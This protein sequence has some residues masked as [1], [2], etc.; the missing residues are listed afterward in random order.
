MRTSPRTSGGFGT[1]ALVLLGLGLLVACADVAPTNPY[2]PATPIAQQQKGQV[3]GTLRLPPG[4]GVDRLADAVVS[5]SAASSPAAS[6]YDSPV[7]V[8]ED[9][10]G[11]RFTF[12]DIDPGAYRLTVGVRGLSA[13]PI[14]LEVGIGARV[15]VG[16]VGLLAD[17]SASVEGVALRGGDAV[18]S[19][20]GILVE[21]LG[22]PYTALTTAEGRFSVSLTPGTYTFRFSVAGHA[23]RERAGVEVRAGATTTLPDPV[24]LLGAP[25]RIRGQVALPAGFDRDRMRDVEVALFAPAQDEPAQVQ[26]PGPQGTFVLADLTPGAWRVEVRLAGFTA[27][28]RVAEV[29]PGGDVDV[30]LITLEQATQAWISGVARLAGRGDDVHGGIAIE[31]VGTPFNGAT[32]SDGSFRL[33]VTPGAHSVRVRFPGYTPQVVPVEALAPLEDR[34]LA[35][36]IVLLG[37]PGRVTGTAALA[38]GFDDRAALA[39]MVVQAR[40]VGEPDAVTVLDVVIDDADQAQI[41][42]A[43]AAGAWDV[44]LQ[45]AGFYPELRRVAVPVGAAVDLG[46]VVLRSLPRNARVTGV[47]QIQGAADHADIA[48]ELVGTPESTRTNSDGDF[49][50]QVPAQADPYRLRVRRAGYEPRL[51]D[52]PGQAPEAV[53]ALEDPIL[54]V[55]QPGSV[56]GVVQIDERFD[57]RAL[58]PQVEVRLSPIIDGEPGEP[59]VTAPT[60]NG[61]YEFDQLPPGAY[62]LEVTLDGFFSAFRA[63][64]VTVGA[65][66]NVG[67]VRLSPNQAQAAIAGTARLQCPTAQCDNG[68]IRVEAIGA[69][70][71]TFTN[72]DGDFQL[73]VVVGEYTLRFVFAGYAAQERGPIAVD[74]GALRDDVEDVLLL[75]LPGRILG[76]LSLPD[77]FDG[78]ALFAQTLVDVFP[79]DAAPA[80]DEVGAP[81][82]RGQVSPDGLFVVSDVTLGEW[83]VRVRVPGFATQV[84]RVELPPGGAADLGVLTLGIRQPARVS[85]RITLEDEVTHGGIQVSVRGQPFTTLTSEDGAFALQVLAGQPQQLVFARDGF[86]TQELALEPVAV[87]EQR[88]LNDVVIMPFL[89][90]AVSGTILRRLPDG[91]TVPAQNATVAVRGDA[92]VPQVGVT[93]AQG[94]YTVGDLRGGAYQVRADLER[95]VSVGRAAQLLPG[96]TL[97]IEPLIVDIERGR[98]IGTATRDDAP[99][100]GGVTVLAVRE[101]DGLDLGDG[102]RA[103]TLSRAPTDAIELDLPVGNWRVTALAE[104][105]RPFGPVVV[106]VR[107]DADTIVNARVA[108][109][110]HRLTAPERVAEGPVTVTLEGDADLTAYK[111]WVDAAPVP[112]EWSVLPADG[113]IAV[114]LAGDGPHQLF[115]Q[116]ATRAEVDAGDPVLRATSPVL[117]AVVVLDGTPPE[118]LPPRIASGDVVTSPEGLVDLELTCLDALSVAA[119]LTV[120]VRVDGVERYAGPYRPQVPVNLGVDEGIKRLE[121]RCT[122]AAGNTAISDAVDVLHDYS[123]PTVATFCLG[124]DCAPGATTNDAVVAVQLDVTDAGAGGVE[125][126]LAEAAFA[127]ADGAYVFGGRGV[128]DVRLSAPGERTLWLCARDR[129]GNTTAAAVES[130]NSITLDQTAPQIPTLTGPTVTRAPG[131][132]VDLA[133]PPEPGLQVALSGDIAP[134]T[135]A[136]E[137]A[138]FAVALTGPDGIKIIQAR[139]IDAAGNLSNAA[140]LLV[141]LDREAPAAGTVTLANGQPVVNSR[142]VPITITDTVADR[143]RFWS[144]A[145]CG[146]P[147]CG[148]DGF[149]D[150]A[151]ATRF[152]VTE[153]LG[154]KR[155]CWQ[156]CDAA[157][158]AS[159]VGT[160]VITLDTYIDRPQ[161]ALVSV[162]RPVIEAFP[163]D[164]SIV[165]TGAGI[166]P[167]T[168]L[169]VDGFTVACASD[170]EAGCSVNGGC[171]QTCTAT[172]PRVVVQNPDT[173][174]LRLFTPAPVA[175]GDGTSADAVVLNVVGPRPVITQLSPRGILES[176][177]DDDTIDVEITGYDFMDNRQVLLDRFVGEVIASEVVDIDDA[178]AGAPQRRLTV[179]FALDGLPPAEDGVDLALTVRNPAPGGGE[180]V[181]AFGWNPDFVDC[182]AL[183]SCETA[184]SYTRA[185]HPDGRGGAQSYLLDPALAGM[186][187]GGDL[188]RLREM[189]GTV[190]G[191]IVRSTVA[192]PPLRPVPVLDLQDRTGRAGRFTVEPTTWRTSGE[193]EAEPRETALGLEK[194][195]RLAVGDIDGDGAADVIAVQHGPGNTP[196]KIQVLTWQDGAL[197]RGPV[198]DEALVATRAFKLVDLDGDLHLDL[199][200][201]T[202]SDLYF[203]R[204]RGDTTFAPAARLG[205][206]S[207]P[208]QL[209]VG[210]IDGDGVAEVAVTDQSDDAVRI[211]GLGP[212]ARVIIKARLD[213]QGAR[214]VA[215]DDI[216]GD[217]VADILVGSAGDTHIR[218]WVGRGAGQFRAPT[219]V[220]IVEAAP[221]LV[222]Q[223]GDLNGDGRV[224][225]LLGQPAGLLGTLGTGAAIFFGV[226]F[227]IVGDAVDQMA[228]ID[229]DGDGLLDALYL[230]DDGIVLH[231]RIGAEL[232]DEPVLLVAG[233]V[234]RFEVADVDG[235]GLLDIISARDAATVELYRGVDGRFAGVYLEPVWPNVVATSQPRWPRT[236]TLVEGRV[237]GL[238]ALD[239]AGVLFT[240]TTGVGVLPAPVLIPMPEAVGA[241]KSAPPGVGDYNG[242]GHEDF[243]FAVS[244]GGIVVGTNAGDGGLEGMSRVLFEN[245]YEQVAFGDFGGDGVHRIAAIGDDLLTIKANGVQP[246]HLDLAAP[247]SHGMLRHGLATGDIDLDGRDDIAY[248]TDDG[249]IIGLSR[250]CDPTCRFDFGDPIEPALRTLELRDMDGDGHLDLVGLETERI[251][252]VHFLLGAGPVATVQVNGFV[253]EAV[254][255][256]D[257]GIDD[258]DGDGRLDLIFAGNVPVDVLGLT[259]QTSARGFAE[260]TAVPFAGDPR[261]IVVDD[262]NN[263][264]S[265]DIV[266][267]PGRRV[268]S[269]DVAVWLRPAPQTLQHRL[270]DMRGPVTIAPG[271]AQTLTVGAARMFLRS[272]GLHVHATSPAGLVDA[273][274][275][276]TDPNGVTVILDAPPAATTAQL[277]VIDAVDGDVNRWLERG[278]WQLEIT[279]TG[280]QA[281]VIDDFAVLA[282]GDYQAGCEAAIVDGTRYLFCAQ[283]LTFDDARAHCQSRGR[284]LVI[285]DTNAKNLAVQAHARATLPGRYWIGLT[286]RAVERDFAWIDGRPDGD[287]NFNAGEPNHGAGQDCVY[288]RLDLD[289]GVW[290]DFRCDARL[291]FVCE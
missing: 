103:V 187:V 212:D 247:A 67:I 230:T 149:T 157:G 184:L 273:R 210:D 216:N 73:P 267:L 81:T 287:F 200:I 127:C 94:A 173:Y 88:A 5:L 172:L 51:I 162:D 180:A 191:G 194:V 290:H 58:M 106:E 249:V 41:S 257:L 55:G 19:H 253:A 123:P 49:A 280:A 32:N 208:G 6:A 281:L 221:T 84:L 214:S 264:G 34:V 192:I 53:F 97:Q 228:L 99:G 120:S 219:N 28:S 82:W 27:P 56:L 169:R 274:F 111:L 31:A 26:A 118:A 205:G 174:T 90:A 288:A 188:A 262:L 43:L 145:N 199:V 142:E 260:T 289:G 72:E 175:G 77:G 134:V 11:G 62:V 44:S 83:A 246:Q 261:G 114:P 98:V 156:F 241:P 285:P 151:P 268:D 57:V 130:H 91:S 138:P 284:D 126:A 59:R 38:P 170:A 178:P 279:N 30:G 18:V 244:E 42:G 239:D 242:D 269:G 259:L 69:P 105:Y 213:A 16:E 65:R 24:I 47:A 102:V 61:V 276:L 50:L 217:G 15:D 122:D 23:P 10:A 243:A 176:A 277:G 60:V 146:D 198:I 167:D 161:P 75:P 124:A 248:S 121:L 189:G 215:I 171:A 263:D 8:I 147:G 195:K 71:V 164:A 211:V 46:H 278:E 223:T 270:T 116:M 125:V 254:D 236:F 234:L 218:R 39:A 104:G 22:T 76:R 271:A 201:A 206:S 258:L 128:V 143:M 250:G 95:H 144:A 14:I 64:E 54:L 238:L 255:T 226:P 52:V 203:L 159:P 7:E 92:E 78:P 29:G 232:A 204:G 233:A 283:R 222:I 179:R 9:P 132:N 45:V 1:C 86:E 85:G 115:A 152:T 220:T 87:G 63:P 109:R 74:A 160:D 80:D 107:A 193:I 66:V 227:E 25:G 100:Q 112:A 108:A 177:R 3:V 117:E 20:G 252:R 129:A 119:D 163:A 93:D 202:A 207:D 40:P 136:A 197:T 36:P 251:A 237:R 79:A 135:R 96:Q 168:V 35:E 150:F 133:A 209:A 68:G 256:Y 181:W 229:F 101:P 225:A 272:A 240:R 131:I 37:E 265:A 224:D 4:F 155:I 186:R 235:D 70:F 266:A 282:R 182:G 286:D 185:M 33:E 17:Q 196:D 165:V 231:R 89:R 245:V 137:D 110:V 158:N 140:Q 2:D 12:G 113:R 291:A 148:A 48:V 190:R 166:A 13:D 183:T 154:A 153:T 141:T 139:F 275:S 21:A